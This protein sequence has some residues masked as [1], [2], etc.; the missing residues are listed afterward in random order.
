M[1]RD[2]LIQ[3]IIKKA[4]SNQLAPF[5]LI[6]GDNSEA[7]SEW[8]KSLI[9]HY[10]IEVKK[11]TYANAL[12]KIDLGLSDLLWI[13]KP[14]DQKEYSIVENDLGEIA[15]FL[16]WNAMELPWRFIVVTDAHLISERYYNKLLKM[17]EE[18]G[19]KISLFFLYGNE[20]G[21]LNTVESRAIIVR[22]L[23]KSPLLKTIDISKID[24]FLQEHAL[25]FK[26]D[27]IVGSNDFLEKLKSKKDLQQSLWDNLILY[28]LYHREKYNDQEWTLIHDELKQASDEEIFH[29]TFANRFQRLL[30][31]VLRPCAQLRDELQ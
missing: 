8:M 10:L 26:D 15:K 9:A 27:R 16:Q 17:L 3:T 29:N 14:A 11:I 4:S 2:S 24:T 22:P 28:A 1:L 19:E 31:T 25:T 23:S 18:P 13:N 30:D 5:Y 20:K 21:I 6:V 7:L 12:A